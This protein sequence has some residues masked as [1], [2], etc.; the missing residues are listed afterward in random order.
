MKKFVNRLLF[1]LLSILIL[2]LE[3]CSNDISKAVD[4][5]TTVPGSETV[6]KQ[7]ATIKIVDLSAAKTINP[8]P[9]LDDFSTFTFSGSMTSGDETFTKIYN[10]SSELRSAEIEIFVGEWTFSLIANSNGNKYSDSV[11]KEIVPG[12]NTV[13]FELHKEYENLSSGYGNL[14]IKLTFPEDVGYVVAELRNESTDVIVKTN[15]YATTNSG[16]KLTYSLENIRS[17]SYIVHFTFYDKNNTKPENNIKLGEYTE[18]V[19]IARE[20]TSKAER[21]ISNLNE[22]YKVTLNLN[23]GRLSN[24]NT[25]ALSYSRYSDNVKLPTAANLSNGTKDFMGWY[26]TSDFTGEPVSEIPVDTLADVILYARWANC[27]DVTYVGLVG[28]GKVRV[29]EGSV[30][31]PDDFEI[32]SVDE[33]IEVVSGTVTLNGELLPE[34]ITVTEN[35]EIDL[36]NAYYY[37]VPSKIGSVY[38]RLTQEGIHKVKI[39]GTVKTDDLTLINSQLQRNSNNA[40]IDLDFSEGLDVDFPEGLNYVIKYV[41]LP[42]NLEAIGNKTFS[43]FMSL[44]T[45]ELPVSVTALGHHAFNNC[46]SLKDITIKGELT[47]IGDYAFSGCK[48]LESIILSDTITEIGSHAFYDCA[49]LQNVILPSNITRIEEYTFDGCTSFTKIDIPEGVTVIDTSALHNCTNLSDVIL[50]STLKTIGK[51][52]FSSCSSLTE[53]VLPEGINSIGLGSFINSGLK[54]MDVPAGAYVGFGAFYD[55]KELKELK[56]PSLSGSYYE[57]AYEDYGVVNNTYAYFCNYNTPVEKLTIK[58]RV[59]NLKADAFKGTKYDKNPNRGNVT[60]KEIILPEN[61]LTVIESHAFRNCYALEKIEIPKTVEKIGF[62][63]FSGCRSLKELALPFTGSDPE[64]DWDFQPTNTKTHYFGFIFDSK[65]PTDGDYIMASQGFLASAVPYYIPQSLSKV[66]VTGTEIR[67]NAFLNCYCIKEIVVEP[68]VTN[69]GPS[70]FGG[71]SWL[72]SLT[73]PFAHFGDKYNQERK[74]LDLFWFG[75]FFSTVENSG[76][77]ACTKWKVNGVDKVVTYLP[78]DLS[79]TITG[80]T[81]IEDNFFVN[82]KSILSLELSDTIETIGKKALIGCSGL[83]NLII[84][85]IGESRT[86]DPCTEESMFGYLFG[87]SAAYDAIEQSYVSTDENG[88]EVEKKLKANFP[89]SLNKVT[90][91]DGAI[92]DYVFSNCTTLKEVEIS[93]RVTGIGTKAFY[94]CTALTKAT[95]GASV[96]AIKASAFLGCSKLVTVDISTEA[97]VS[98]IGEKAFSTT[99]ITSIYLADTITKIEDS[100]FVGTKLR[101]INIPDSV[102]S[103]GQRVFSGCS[104]LSSVTIPESVE[105][106]GSECFMNCSSLTEINLPGS[107]TSMGDNLFGGCYNLK[108][109]TIPFLGNTGTESESSEKT[110]FGNMFKTKSTGVTTGIQQSYSSEVETVTYYIPENLTKVSVLHGNILNG[111]FENCNNI[112]EI[113]IPS[114]SVIIGSNAFTG[115]SIS[116]LIL[117][118][119]VNSIGEQAFNNC[120][121]L[122]SVDMAGTQITE[123]SDGL[124]Y[125]CKSLKNVSLPS[126]ITKIG[127]QAFMECRVIDQVSLPEGV[128]EIGDEAFSSCR[129]LSQVNIPS[130]VISIGNEAYKSASSITE[131][132]LPEGLK[133]IGNNA[134]YY[135]SKLVSCNIPSTLEEIGDGVFYEC[136]LLEGA[137]NFPE[138][139]TRLG[140]NLFFNCSKISEVSIPGT[141]TE[142]GRCCFQNCSG[143]TTINNLPE[144]LT[145]IGVLAF[146]GCSGITTRFVFPD[147]LKT[148]GGGAFTG[149]NVFTS[150][151]IPDS[152]DEIGQGAFFGC[153][154]IT[155][156]TVP[157]VGVKRNN[158]NTAFVEIFSFNSD[159]SEGKTGATQVKSYKSKSGTQETT[160]GYV[161]SGLKSITVTGGSTI[162]YGAF[163]NLTMVSQITLPAEVTKIAAKAFLMESSD[164]E[165]TFVI[166]TGDKKDWYW[167]KSP[168]NTTSFTYTSSADMAKKLIANSQYE[169]Y[170]KN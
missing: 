5:T 28:V 1:I 99:S 12:L 73:L 137:F 54:F 155:S 64:V 57:Y 8:I 56:L 144:G 86:V 14:E 108:E 156:I 122:T 62:E 60:I 117:P 161:P 75:D 164:Y 17:G 107:I 91:L 128:T 53:I 119:S 100:A 89:A 36:G 157:F 83:Q 21:Q 27:F 124:F 152:V 19:N 95:L 6:E 165:L 162:N 63:A 112:S 118:E 159:Y 131:V 80:G 127:K 50:P 102:S 129:A 120:L 70:A 132:I 9:T 98:I 20:L 168:G 103:I 151:K 109:L 126:T 160:Y 135:C 38:A 67:K 40:Y 58:G 26:T 163:S 93:D 76:M 81:E 22:L 45:I 31:T 68:S 48:K 49:S 66:R 32:I 10:S 72:T 24:A 125:Y 148:I 123:V 33:G 65:Q 92:N 30:L 145:C 140:E 114:D 16:G 169:F 2:T 23:G 15:S 139:I 130:T 94:G 113:I 7:T 146:A 52:C 170:L 82:C 11:T 143:I 44:E 104:I 29:E 105:S 34:S 158:S 69:I 150:L 3:S 4:T 79:V 25:F 97:P 134:F 46:L 138:G 101:T 133:K 167:V 78:N 39:K 13:L 142:I 116:E 55:C 149:V 88:D 42:E 96:D 59:N 18:L 111:A 37:C 85:F 71:C 61:D 35:L 90:V 77:T 41:K 115:T 147:G 87:P 166:C 47:S 153:N 141:V 74:D 110:L 106:I 84:P 43:G 51:S 121:L 154:K 136:K